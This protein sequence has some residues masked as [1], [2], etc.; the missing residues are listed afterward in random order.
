MG[1][2]LSDLESHL[3]ESANILRGSIDSG[4]FKNYILGLMFLKRINDV[5]IEDREG[6]QNEPGADVDD[7]LEY[8]F[9]VPDR[10]RWPYLR[11]LSTNIGEA[12]NV[13]FESLEEQNRQ[14]EGVLVSI[15]FNHKER[16]PDHVLLR[17]LEHF[18]RIVL[19]NRNLSEPDMLGRAYEYLIAQ[20]ADDAGKKGGEFYTPRPV[21]RLIIELLQP[22]EGMRICD[23]TIGSGGMLIESVHYI[24]R[25]GGNPRNVSLYGQEKNLNTWSI[26]KMNMLLHGLV[27]ARIEK[28]D[29]IRDPKLVEHG[30]LMLFDRVIANPP[31][32]LKNWGREEAEHD[33]YGRFKSGLHNPTILIVTDRRDLDRQITGT[34]QR[35]GFPN[36]V[37]VG[38]ITELRDRLQYGGPGQTLMTT[39]QK[40]QTPQ[41]AATTPSPI[42][43]EDRNLF[44]MVDEAHRT[45]YQGLA[46]NMRVALP[47]ATFLG[48]TGTPIEKKDRST[49]ATFGSY[50]DTYT[51]RQS[52]ADHAT[53]PIFYESRLPDVHVDGPSLDVLFDRVFKD[54]PPEDREAIKQRYANLRSIIRSPQRI[55]QICLDLVQH[56]ETHI[57]PNGF[58]AQIV[59]MDRS[60]AALYQE[61][62]VRLRAPESAVI[63]SGS[64]DDDERLTRYALTKSQEDAL[65]DRFKDPHDSLS[66]VVVCDKLLTGFDAPVEQVLYLDDGLRDHT[67]LQAIARVNRPSTGTHGEKTYGLVVDYY[68]IGTYLDQALAMFDEIDMQNTIKPLT[69]D[70][71]NLEQAHRTVMR[72]FD[73]LPRE[74]LDALVRHLEPEDRRLHFE[75]A[76]IT[77]ARHLDRVLPDLVV[78]PYLDDMRWL[79]KIR[80]AMKNRYW[81]ETLDWKSIGAKVTQLIDEH[82]RSTGV[83]VLL[84]PLSILDP[85]FH[86]QVIENLPTPEAKAHE[87]EHALRHEIRVRQDQNPAG[88]TSLRQRLDELIAAYKQMR[89]SLAELLK[90]LATFA[91]EAR[92]LTA[93]ANAEGLSPDVLAFRRELSAILDA[94]GQKT[95]PMT[96]LAELVIENLE[97]LKVIDW[98]V[99]ED[100]QREMQKRIRRQLRVAGVTDAGT[101]DRVT[102]ELMRLAKVRLS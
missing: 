39:V 82:V 87:M 77:F 10:S 9:F 11:S 22:T 93:G 69:D 74:D 18:G 52:V 98:Q 83:T 25:Q 72:I 23:P 24:E 41:T 85:A 101:L 60:T 51:I 46:H 44:V 79:G 26:V 38:S 14:L 7:P 58:K 102:G 50:I 1:L 36:P 54:Y 34:F 21:V 68:G 43:S 12:I 63:I 48:F 6:L 30:E 42:L 3:W 29:T 37:R 67:L 89:L 64:N 61:T 81:E 78:G 75:T 90:Q 80:L 16:L 5:F 95:E 47:H 100:V 4:D 33:A 40:F 17:L 88:W 94:K 35:C 15:D 53:V 70:L 91:Q 66:I 55:Q 97:R 96:A 92:D 71:P 27:D 28:G 2:T 62:L 59:A 31:F 49:P 56:Y 19:G 84:E 32:S 73:G 8:Q 86:Q 20:F 99:K 76:F 57:Q 45:Q 65:V 13:A